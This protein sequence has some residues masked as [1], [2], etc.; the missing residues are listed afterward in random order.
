ML[1]LAIKPHLPDT[2]DPDDCAELLSLKRGL[3]GSYGETY[4]LGHQDT[5]LVLTRSGSLG[6]FEMV[7]LPPD[8]LPTLRKDRWRNLLCVETD[9]GKVHEL[10]LSN[11]EG[12]GADLGKLGGLAYLRIGV[13]E[14]SGR[15]PSMSVKPYS[16]ASSRDAMVS[17]TGAFAWR[18]PFSG[19]PASPKA[20]TSE[21]C[22][23]TPVP[24]PPWR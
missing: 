11:E 7:T 4:L 15:L 16:S 17:R 9:D 3:D 24:R 21:A 5:M 2:I 8:R 19:W 6:G 1:S 22:R 12:G 23:E 10:E 18:S 20:F 14:P 13:G